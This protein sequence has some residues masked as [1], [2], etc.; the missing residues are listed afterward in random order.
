M[1]EVDSHGVN[2]VAVRSTFAAK[3]IPARQSWSEFGEVWR[4]VEAVGQDG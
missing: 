2:A 4:A 3:E 1:D